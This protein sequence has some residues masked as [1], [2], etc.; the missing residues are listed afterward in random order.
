MKGPLFRSGQSVAW[1]DPD[2]DNIMKPH[3]G[4]VVTWDVHDGNRLYMVQES[5]DEFCLVLEEELR[6][7]RERD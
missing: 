6:P 3:V 1:V 2:E 5:K 7:L 4:V